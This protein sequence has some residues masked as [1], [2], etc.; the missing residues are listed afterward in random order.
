MKTHLYTY[1]A[2]AIW[3]VASVLV[4]LYAPRTNNPTDCQELAQPE[5]EPVLFLN[6]Q[7]LYTT[8]PQR[9]WVGLTDEELIELSESGLHLWELWKAIEAKLKEKNT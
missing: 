7:P 2:I 4:L 6:N 9:Q 5:Q 3:A 8:P 1:I